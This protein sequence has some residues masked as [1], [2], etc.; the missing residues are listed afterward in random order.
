MIFS[1][2]NSGLKI[3]RPSSSLLHPGWVTF[4]NFFLLGS[5][6]E[7]GDT[8]FAHLPT[9]FHTEA[10]DKNDRFFMNL[11]LEL[12]WKTIQSHVNF[13]KCLLMWLYDSEGLMI[14]II[15]NKEEK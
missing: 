9:S 4:G 8:L 11:I 5:H 13:W 7:N 15:K 3:R 1:V 10:L 6:L 14:Q 12:L 2:N